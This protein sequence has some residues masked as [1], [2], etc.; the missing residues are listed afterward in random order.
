MNA[1]VT[2]PRED[3]DARALSLR[4]I[5][6]PGVNDATFGLPLPISRRNILRGGVSV[7]I[8]FLIASAGLYGLALE[9][10]AEVESDLT[11]LAEERADG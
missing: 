6:P 2:V 8:D 5:P 10:G 4:W 9:R 11:F 7:N 1:A 3:I